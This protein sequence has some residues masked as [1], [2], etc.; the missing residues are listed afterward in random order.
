MCWHNSHRPITQ[1]AYEYK[2]KN[3]QI[4]ATNENTLKRSNKL[5][6]KIMALLTLIIV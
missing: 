3:T 5:H 1:T 4:Q 2:K 6:I